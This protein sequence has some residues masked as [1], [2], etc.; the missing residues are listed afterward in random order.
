MNKQFK[1]VNI[2]ELVA[3]RHRPSFSPLH[4]PQDL[5]RRRR[6]AHHHPCR[7][8]VDLGRRRQ[9]ASRRHVGAVVREH[10]L[11]PQGAGG[12]RLSPDARSALLQYL[13]QDL[14]GAGNASLPPRSPA[15]CRSASS[16]CFSSI[17]ARKPTTRWCASCATTGRSRA[18][19]TA[20]SSSA[21]VAA[22]TARR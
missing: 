13:L 20:T 19:N 15:C 5:S 16:A 14:D 17:R 10:R 4:R 6:P 2:A 22:I 11:R 18:R 9:S 8:R 21:A 3:A 1:N 7:G 12:S